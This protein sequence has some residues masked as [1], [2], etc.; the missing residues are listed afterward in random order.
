MITKVHHPIKLLF[1]ITSL[2][3]ISCSNE[4]RGE[5]EVNNLVSVQVQ[6][7]VQHSRDDITISGR[8]ESQSTANIS[9]RVMGFIS[10]IK[11][12]IGDRVEKGQ[13]LVV[14][15]SDEI[16]ARRA[17]ATAVISEA[18][19]A[20]KD[21][22][23]D[24]ERFEILYRQQSATAKEYEN[25]LLRYTSAKSKADAAI[26]SKKEADAMLAYTN[27]IAPFSGTITQKHVDEGSLT[28]PGMPILTLEQ[29]TNY[30]K[31][32]VSENDI[33]KIRNG[34]IADVTV[35]STGKKVGGKITEISPSSNFSGGQFQIKLITDCSELYAGMYV[36]VSIPLTNASGTSGLFVP[37]SAII[38]RDQLSGLYTVG[39]DHTAQLRWLTVGDQIGEEV[40]ILSGL[41]AHEAF[42]IKSEGKLYSGVPVLVK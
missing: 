7:P 16:V 1:G 17:Q 23:K 4:E 27:L 6:T 32:S 10:E 31:A 5:M 13:L 21:A 40:E 25:A 36:N 28:R 20:L 3:L 42:I 34:M 29:S 14:V 15:D 8:V 26:Q 24:Y 2:L 39:D 37:A 22:Q 38:Q 33:S 18:E 19:A 12:S 41:S 30:I 11:V 35:K 9:T